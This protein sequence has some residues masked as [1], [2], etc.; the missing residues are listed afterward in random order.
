MLTGRDTLTAID[1]A[2]ATARNEAS[3]IDRELG[4]AS[5]ELANVRQRETA[6][7]AQLAKLRLVAIETGSLVD[8]LDRVDQNVKD[9]LAQREEAAA[10]TDRKIADADA[11]L[12]TREHK[13]AE[14]Q[15]VV[16]AASEAVDK[17]EALA[18][19][20]LSTDATYKAELATTEKAQFV[21]E[22]A[23]AKAKAAQTDRMEKGAPYEK[24][25][26]F[27]Y[28]W[29]RHY[30][31]G[32]YRAWRLARLLDRWVAGICKYEPARRNYA[33]L[34]EIPVR[35]RE[36]AA[37]MRE[38]ADAETEA[39]RKLEHEAAEAANVFVEQGR[40][41]AAEATLASIDAS[42]AA[43]ED[44]IRELTGERARFA[45]GEDDYYRRCIEMLSEA[46]QREDVALLRAR[47]TRTGSEEDDRLV[48]ELAD[49]EHERARIA[50]DIEQFRKLQAAQRGR[51]ID[52]ED[53]RRRFKSR[54]YDDMH[55]IFVN[56]P[57]IAMVLK[58]FLAGAIRSGELWDAIERQQRHR[59]VRANPRFGT[60]RFPRL[61]SGDP[62]RI[63]KGGGWH[64]PRTGGRGGGF[65]GGGF[66]TGGGF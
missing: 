20:Q 23:E 65:R 46:L 52:F 39:L 30:G 59:P 57:L 47:A 14:Q 49:L 16:E 21:A 64:F 18:Q 6:V 61:P 24:D 32:E 2:L 5:T 27:A 4:A 51:L 33:M 12:K 19:Q 13:R 22:Q 41:D 50:R 31:T 48:D 56:G 55:S 34:T 11:E 25:P 37:S 35:L 3:G 7:F 53:V 10:R 42:I 26:L 58:Q 17:A 38:H 15:S 44:R 36:H 60:G 1:E 29:A 66:K 54:R 62:W 63:P 40:L 43:Q 9:L 28:L 8:T 45:G